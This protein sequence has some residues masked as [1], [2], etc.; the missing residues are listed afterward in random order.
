MGVLDYFIGTA[1]SKY[2][3]TA[4]FAAII[5]ISLMVLFT[6]TD[7]SIGNRI[8]V[9]LL[10]VL[11]SA[12]PILISLFELTCIVTGGKNTKF[13]LCNI[14]A[15]FVT[16]IIVVYCFILIIAA[17]LSMFS[18]K[19]ALQK[20][21]ITE[22]FNK[23]SKEDA[24]QIAKNILKEEHKE[25]PKLIQQIHKDE[26]KERAQ[27]R[28]KKVQ[29]L[30]DQTRQH[31]ED[32]EVRETYNSYPQSVM[33]TIRAAFRNARIRQGFEL[34]DTEYNI[35][36][37]SEMLNMTMPDVASVV[38]KMTPK[39]EHF[40]NELSGYG[41][42]DKY[43]EIDNQGSSFKPVPQSVLP[44]PSSSCNS[45]QVEA[46]SPGMENFSNI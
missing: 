4:M 40:E 10:I 19:K 26:Q 9:V 45:K 46:F 14:F 41:N 12:F 35:P 25:N 11:M 37:P 15:W 27:E 44:T 6:N 29:Q 23:I 20:I 1:Q 21:E 17:L 2:A 5:V 3:G 43:M 8:G 38:N 7:I 31:N 13:N 24:N 18:Y 34:Q 16:A 39:R 42:D 30:Q 33:D 32:N 36:T 22:N 28:E